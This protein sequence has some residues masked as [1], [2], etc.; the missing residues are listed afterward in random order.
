MYVLSGRSLVLLRALHVMTC[1]ICLCGSV[2]VLDLLFVIIVLAGFCRG[3]I[4]GF[5]DNFEFLDRVTCYD[6]DVC[7]VSFDIY[8]SKIYC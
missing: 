4:G 7:C 8:F 1:R 5:Y 2:L 6:S 3:L